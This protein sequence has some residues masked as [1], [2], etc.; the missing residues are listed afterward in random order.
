MNINAKNNKGFKNKVRY[1][2][3]KINKSTKNAS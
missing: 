2:S 1:L 3:T